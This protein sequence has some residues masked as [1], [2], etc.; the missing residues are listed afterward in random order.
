MASTARTMEWKLSA[1]DIQADLDAHRDIV[2]TKDAS[3]AATGKIDKDVLK[4]AV[5]GRLKADSELANL[6]I[7]VNPKATGEIQLEGKALTADQVGKAIALTL[8]TDGVTKV[9]SKIKLDKDAVKH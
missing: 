2:R 4:S 8:D 3:G 6:K 7:D 1:N 5:E 9:T